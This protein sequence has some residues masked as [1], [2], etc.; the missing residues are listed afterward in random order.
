MLPQAHV[1]WLAPQVLSLRLQ[2]K[3]KEKK[4]ACFYIAG[5]EKFENDQFFKQPEEPMKTSQKRQAPSE[6][7]LNLSSLHDEI[8]NR[9]PDVYQSQIRFFPANGIMIQAMYKLMKPNGVLSKEGFSY[10]G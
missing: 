2:M 3:R 7:H 8:V 6:E 10:S 5:M 9:L 1:S 4:R